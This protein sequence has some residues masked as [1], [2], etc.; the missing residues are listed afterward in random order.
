MFLLICSFRMLVKI[1]LHNR[2]PF[3]MY[4]NKYAKYSLKL[5]T[6]VKISIHIIGEVYT[7]IRY[8]SYY[9]K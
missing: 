9:Y 3:K 5:K 6:V 4:I 2:L 8:M 7:E 1:Y